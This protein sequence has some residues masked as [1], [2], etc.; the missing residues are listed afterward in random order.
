MESLF[1]QVPREREAER[2]QERVHALIEKDDCKSLD[3]EL[4]KFDQKSLKN[5]L[6]LFLKR[7]VEKSSVECLGLLIKLGCDINSTD[8]SDGNTAM[9]LAVSRNDKRMIRWLLEHGASSD[10]V[11]KVGKKPGDLCTDP[12]V[13]Q[14]FKR[15]LVI[16]VSRYSLDFR[17]LPTCLISEIIGRWSIL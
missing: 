4:Q 1:S 5:D 2:N 11:N 17:I 14:L 3:A 6:P 12:K 9:H 10:K 8:V 15:T 7:C 16:Q 13:L